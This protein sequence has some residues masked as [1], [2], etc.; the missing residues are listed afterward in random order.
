MLIEVA[1]SNEQKTDKDKPD[2]SPLPQVCGFYVLVRPVHIKDEKTKGGIYIPQEVQDDIRYL[3]NV[4]RVLSI[5]PYAFKSDSFKHGSWCEGGEIQVG[6]YV[7]F[8]RHVG[9]PMVFKNVNLRLIKDVDIKLRVLDPTD[10]DTF[11]NLSD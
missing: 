5:G 1:K 10:V 9:Q 3:T 2:P 8:G 7:A 6:D 4:G 11:S